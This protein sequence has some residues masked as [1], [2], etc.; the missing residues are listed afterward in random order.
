MGRGDAMSDEHDDAVLQ[1]LLDRLLQFRLPRALA[2]KKRVDAGE[3]LTDSDIEFLKVALEDAQAGKRYVARNPEF[4]RI[5]TQIAQ[6]YADIV[7][8]AME[9]E[10]ERGGS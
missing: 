4:H 9:N 8:R 5:G 6:L 2:L 1:T 7:N 10:K 3:C